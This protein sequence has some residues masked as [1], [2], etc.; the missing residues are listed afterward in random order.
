MPMRH[1][2]MAAMACAIVLCG[3]MQPAQAQPAPDDERTD[4]IRDRPKVLRKLWLAT[5]GTIE[6]SLD[7]A[8]EAVDFITPPSARSLASVQGDDSGHFF[9]LLGHAGYKLKEIDN[10]IG[11]IP[12]L[13]IKFGLVREMSEADLDFL[14]EQ[15]D[16][17]RTRSPGMLGELQR[18]IVSTVAAIN[19]GGG[20]QV[21]EL[22]LTLLPLP[23]AQFSITPSE[24]VLG[25][26]MSVL[27]RAIQR[28]DRRVRERGTAEVKAAA[29][30]QPR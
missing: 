6:W 9:R 12:G 13:S 27:L 5:R 10:E 2:L 22:K 25:E 8:A 18:G 17:F 4:L 26:E 1:L 11:L 23:T 15:M 30:G 21:S 7:A 14:D 16:L 19:S 20:M 24:T 28:V 3:P 29:A